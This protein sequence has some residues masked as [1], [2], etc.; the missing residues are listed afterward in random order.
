[1]RAANQNLEDQQDTAKFYKNG[2]RDVMQLGRELQYGTRKP[3]NIRRTCGSVLG[4]GIL[5]VGE[6]P[7]ELTR[8]L[9]LIIKAVGHQIVYGDCGSYRAE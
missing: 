1:M 4:V 8:P 5:P 6:L 2:P 9:N 7:D 3:S